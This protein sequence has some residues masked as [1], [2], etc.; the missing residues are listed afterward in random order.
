[1]EISSL[2]SSTGAAITPTGIAYDVDLGFAI[3]TY[4]GTGTAGNTLPNPLGQVPG[5]MIGKNRSISNSSWP[6]YHSAYGGTYMGRLE[7]TN[8]FSLDPSTWND[9]D[10]TAS[11]ITLGNWSAI[12]GSGNELALYLFANTDAIKVGS[13][14]GNGDADGPFADLGGLMLWGFLRNAS[15]NGG[16]WQIVNTVTAP[17]NVIDS[18]FYAEASTPEITDELHKLDAIAAGLKIRNNN[19]NINGNGNTVI[20]LALLD[21][22]FGGSNVTQGK[23]R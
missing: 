20:Y 18:Y 6:V 1:G 3:V 13:Y 5:M 17:T 15:I 2:V 22:Y 10:P 4:T 19:D 8:A 11:L 14:T 21:P 12:N 23:A 16:S 9:T 7:S